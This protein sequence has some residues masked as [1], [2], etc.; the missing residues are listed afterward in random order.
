MIIGG[1]YGRLLRVLHLSRFSSDHRSILLVTDS[2]HASPKKP[3]FQ[4]L[5][6]WQSNSEFEPLLTA[7]WKSDI[8][9]VQN[10]NNFQGLEKV[11][12]SSSVPALID[13]AK[14][15]DE[16]SETL[17][18]EELLWFQRAHTEWIKDGDRN[19]KYYHHATKSR[20]RQKVVDFFKKVFF[21]SSVTG[22]DIRGKFPPLSACD[23]MRLTASMGADEVRKPFSL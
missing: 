2:T 4:Y 6:A 14:L 22:W 5:V 8:S 12:E 11:N 17:Q 20:H 16:L 1:I 23:V 10:I 18:Q 7:A 13:L 9:I 15:R 3:V 21:S 19:T